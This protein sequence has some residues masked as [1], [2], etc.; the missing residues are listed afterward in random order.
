MESWRA[1]HDTVT[2]IPIVGT[3]CTG[4]YKPP[5]NHS[6]THPR[7]RTVRSPGTAR[8]WLWLL[9]YLHAIALAGEPTPPGRFSGTEMN[10]DV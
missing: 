8:R 1:D 3:D 7:R 9:S 2:S 10:N 4:V 6:L 5:A